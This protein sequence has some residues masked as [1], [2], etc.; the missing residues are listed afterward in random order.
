[1]AM[2][3]AIRR[4]LLTIQGKSVAPGD[5]ERTG[6]DHDFRIALAAMLVHAGNIDGLFVESE[7]I[8]VCN[9]LIRQLGIAR[10]E[11]RELMLLV[12]YRSLLAEEVEEL[13]SS[14]ATALDAAGQVHFIEW[15]WSVI[16]ADA[17][18]VR[19][20]TGLVARLA[21]RLGLSPAQSAE[22]AA[23]YKARVNT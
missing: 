15:V 4:L 17:R 18:I 10:L 12:D 13:V 9:L 3:P 5:F 6:I 1:M 14:I 21:C 11:A 23:R 2:I 7:K 8:E 20:E 22:I 16:V 19:E